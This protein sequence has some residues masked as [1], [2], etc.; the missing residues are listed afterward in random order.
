MEEG[1]ILVSWTENLI[2]EEVIVQR[3]EA[4]IHLLLS[5]TCLKHFMDTMDKIQNSIKR[6]LDWQSVQL[7]WN[8]IYLV[9]IVNIFI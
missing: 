4:N 3:V 2:E 9:L 5:F 6:E 8:N 1:E 7:S